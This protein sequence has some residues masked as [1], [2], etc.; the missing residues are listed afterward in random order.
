[1]LL[2]CPL[3]AWFTWRC[4]RRDEWL[5]A[6]LGF[7]SL[8]SFVFPI[9]F[10]Y[11]VDRSSTRLPAT[12]L[13][14]WL[15]L[16]FPLLVLAYRQGRQV[17]RATL[18]VG[19]AVTALGG[20]VILAVMMVAIQAPQNPYFIA[21]EDV[22]IARR[23]WD[24]LGSGVQILDSIPERAITIFGRA[25]HARPSIYTTFSDYQA[26]VANP[27]PSIT[28]K[29]G[30]SYIYMT[31]QWWSMLSPDQKQAFDRSCVQKIVTGDPGV[32]LFRFLFDIRKCKP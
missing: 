9:F 13:W 10:Q 17:L 12:A 27:E 8:V 25:S 31:N 32:D 11:G 15:L 19:Y 2:I 26:L 5:K 3:V 4:F 24:K 22:I 1:V 14:I 7:A 18:G 28:A 23:Y 20:I 21:S 29:A 6:G 16:G 30:Y